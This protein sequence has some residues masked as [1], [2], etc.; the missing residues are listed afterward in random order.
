MN[1]KR[2]KVLRKVAANL[3]SSGVYEEQ[4]TE[5]QIYR[6]VKKADKILP[7]P[8]KEKFNVNQIKAALS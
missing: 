1:Q 5:R 6:R 2:A 8:M 4:V 7:T 3:K